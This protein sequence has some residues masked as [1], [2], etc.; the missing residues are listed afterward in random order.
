MDIYEPAKAELASRDVV[1]RWMMYHIAQGKG[2]PSPYGDHLWLDIRHLG[3]KHITTKLREV[4]D[5]CRHFL[6]VNPINQLI[7]VRPAQHYSMGG[8]R[9]NSDGAAYGL[10]GLF[11]CG[12]SACWDMHG[13]NRLGGNSLAETIVAGRHVGTKVVEFLEGAEVTL[14]S[15][16]AD[17]GVVKEAER[18][19]RL[20]SR[21]DGSENVYAIKDA[22]QLVMMEKVG[23]FRNGGDLQAAV[24]SLREI[25]AKAKKIGLRSSGIGAN[26]ELSLALKMPGMVRLAICVAYGA[27]MRTESRG[28]HARDDYQ[29]RNDR[30][31]LNRTLAYWRDLDADLPELQYEPSTKVMYMPPGDRGYG[32]TEIIPMDAPKED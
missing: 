30:D 26:P 13:F 23:I 7:P 31:W 12:E 15:R 5:L 25:Y 11:S 17:E 14:K 9:T 8:V 22:M 19:E 27:L 28:C 29:A 3:A 20:V 2:V 10:K 24:D 18:I 16:L 4:Y 32:K 1:S 21:A 6:G